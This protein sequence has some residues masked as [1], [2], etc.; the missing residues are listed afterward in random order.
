MDNSI[1][2]NVNVHISKIKSDRPAQQEKPKVQESQTHET[3]MH[4]D[5]KEYCLCI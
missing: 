3:Q 1:N 5:P 4:Y 2:S